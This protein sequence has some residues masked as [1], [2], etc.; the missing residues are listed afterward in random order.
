MVG[1]SLGGDGDDD[2][3]IIEVDLRHF[4]AAVEAVLLD[5]F[6]KQ[7]LKI[8]AET[9]KNRPGRWKS[10]KMIRYLR[11]ADE[12]M[13]KF[14]Y[15]TSFIARRGP[16]ESALGIVCH[17]GNTRGSSFDGNISFDFV[18]VPFRGACIAEECIA[19]Q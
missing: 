6:K 9:I 17:P 5:V 2:A 14:L 12:L 8:K 18:H 19:T 7:Q 11:I 13:L 16:L 3:L 10:N 1:P 4:P 15:F